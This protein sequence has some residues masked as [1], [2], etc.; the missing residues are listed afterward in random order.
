MENVAAVLT[1][2]D[3]RRS[4]AWYENVLLF[5]ASYLNEVAGS[6]ESL[7]YAVLRNGN[8]SVHLGLH[9]DMGVPAGQGACNFDVR[10]Y[11][12]YLR[13]AQDAEA[14]FY[15]PPGQIPTGQRT[16][17]IKDPDGNLLSFVDVG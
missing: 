2:T 15:L 13:R 14:T 17:G 5:E 3:M 12:E 4:L 9:G 11:D 6:P 16:F 7:N 10:E 8:V 1:V